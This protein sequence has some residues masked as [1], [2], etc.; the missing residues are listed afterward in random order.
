[1]KA[2]Y[3]IIVAALLAISQLP[4]GSTECNIERV[5]NAAGEQHAPSWIVKDS[6]GCGFN[7]GVDPFYVMKCWVGCEVSGGYNTSD[8]ECSVWDIDKEADDDDG[9]D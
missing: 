2:T 1:M 9:L 7:R 5:P 8:P 6:D 4:E 3:G